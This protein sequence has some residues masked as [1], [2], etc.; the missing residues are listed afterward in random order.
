[1]R[2]TP[3]HRDLGGLAAVALRYLPRTS[4]LLLL[5]TTRRSGCSCSTSVRRR[6]SAS[7]CLAG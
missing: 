6:T 1:M 5:T 2:R 7:C 4:D 3:E